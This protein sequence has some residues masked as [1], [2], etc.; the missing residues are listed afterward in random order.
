MPLA[1]LRI[2]TQHLPVPMREDTH[3]GVSF[4]YGHEARLSSFNY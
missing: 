2:S 3:R 1:V 4:I